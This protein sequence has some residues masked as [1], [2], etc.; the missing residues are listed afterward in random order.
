MLMFLIPFNVCVVCGD[1]CVCVFMYA[2]AQQCPPTPP[3]HPLTITDTY[4]QMAGGNH[5]ASI[6]TEEER[7]G[8][9][10]PQVNI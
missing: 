8:E 5:D 2:A 7:G 4:G 10:P 1:A 9:T 3:P 6:S